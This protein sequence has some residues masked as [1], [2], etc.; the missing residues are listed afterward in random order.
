M[1][2][3]SRMT[4]HLRLEAEFV[5]PEA[6]VDVVQ[7]RA[8]PMFYVVDDE[9]RVHFACGARGAFGM[10]RLP[11][12][13]ERIV[14]NLLQAAREDDAVPLGVDGDTIVRIVQTY[15]ELARLKGVVVEK[16]RVRDPLQEAIV[17]FGISTREADVLRLL[18][19]GSSTA[20]IAKQL[21]IA[22]ATAC[23]HVAR[24]ASKTGS[25]GRAQ[26]VARVLGFL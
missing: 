15:S 16:L 1:S 18:L 26:I 23:E 7:R 21:S 5:R 6:P 22:Q 10:D 13:V 3:L 24:I 11:A 2:T 25:R 4:E 14:R 19:Q 9:L 20:S 8:I 17:R 12:R